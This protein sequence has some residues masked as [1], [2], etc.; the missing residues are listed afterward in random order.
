MQYAVLSYIIVTHI[1]IY[2]CYITILTQG[3]LS[4]KPAVRLQTSRFTSF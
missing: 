2:H 3:I 1:I 4:H